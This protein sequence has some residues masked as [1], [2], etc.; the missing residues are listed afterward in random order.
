ML[1]DLN[2]S[3]EGGVGLASLLFPDIIP[4][5]MFLHRSS[6][7]SSF[8]AFIFFLISLFIF[9]CKSCFSA[10]VLLLFQLPSLVVQI[11]NLVCDP[12]STFRALFPPK[13][14]FKCLD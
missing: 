14:L 3:P 11:Q 2:E 13:D 5:S 10:C 8:A 4:F 1:L 6:I 7:Q 12:G 9:R